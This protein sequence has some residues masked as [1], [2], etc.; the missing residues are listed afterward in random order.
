LERTITGFDFG[1]EDCRDGDTAVVLRN[2]LDDR[3]RSTRGWKKSRP[4]NI[5]WM[6]CLKVNGTEVCVGVKIQLSVSAQSDLLLVD[7]QYLYD[8]I[9][10]GRIDVAVLV[11][12]SNRLAS[13][14]PDGVAQFT[15]AVKAIDRANAS[16]L[17]LAVL[18]LEHDGA[19]PSLLKPLT[20]Q[21]KK[22][23]GNQMSIP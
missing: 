18:A 14:L 12:P 2:L 22:R 9:M 1:L 20:H 8:E 13:F 11:V 4:R 16:D 10:K 23:L 17:P 15:D 6:R 21:G 7:L 3:F 19:G 5:D